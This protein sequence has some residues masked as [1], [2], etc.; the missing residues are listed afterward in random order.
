MTDTI[1]E[2]KNGTL[3]TT[4][5]NMSLSVIVIQCQMTKSLVISLLEKLHSDDMM[6]PALTLY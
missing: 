6:T 2:N 3:T 1:P 5:C 4:I